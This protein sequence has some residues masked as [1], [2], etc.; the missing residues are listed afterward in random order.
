MGFPSGVKVSQ[1]LHEEIRVVFGILD[2]R[3]KTGPSGKKLQR[4]CRPL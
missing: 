2:Q 4:L 1:W 3:R